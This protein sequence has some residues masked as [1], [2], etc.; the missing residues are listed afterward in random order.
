MPKLIVTPRAERDLAL[1]HDWYESQA[2]GLGKRLIDQVHESLSAIADHPLR[3][4]EVT[5][6]VRRILLKTYPYKIIYRLTG[7]QIRVLAVYHTARD[8]RRWDDPRRD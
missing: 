6:G 4:P 7:E 1:A 5:R 8:P 2:P 3:Y